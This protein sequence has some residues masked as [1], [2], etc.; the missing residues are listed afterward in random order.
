MTAT[1]KHTLKVGDVLAAQW[2]Y[3]MQI[4]NFYQVTAL[5]GRTQAVIREIEQDGTSTGFLRGTTKPKIDA[6]LP[7]DHNRKE[8]TCRVFSALSDGAPCV[9][10]GNS[11]GNAYR[12]DEKKTYH[13][14]HCD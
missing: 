2:G 5:K 10:P 4:V 3:S 6:F 1:P 12:Y 13:F 8:I 9:K 7:L 14:D 11:R